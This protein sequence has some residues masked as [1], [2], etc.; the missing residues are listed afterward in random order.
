MPSLPAPIPPPPLPD[1]DLLAALEDEALTLAR[2]IELEEERERCEQNLVY[3]FSKAWSVIDS[4]E[5]SVNWHHEVSASTWK[6][7]L[8]EKSETS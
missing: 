5:L 1:N 8:I 7:L 2:A 4:S 6:Q 3:F